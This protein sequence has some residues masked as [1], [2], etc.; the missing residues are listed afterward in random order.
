MEF[1]RAVSYSSQTGDTS[2][3][4]QAGISANIVDRE[5]LYDPNE[6][7]SPEEWQ[8][9]QDTYRG[10]KIYGSSGAALGALTGLGVLHFGQ[11]NRGRMKSPFWLRFLFV[12]SCAGFGSVLMMKFTLNKSMGILQNW[13]SPGR[14]LQERKYVLSWINSDEKQKEKVQT[15][16]KQKT[17]QMNK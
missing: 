1:F 14:L 17:A 2:M 11:F 9:A 4:T 3:M 13:D 5:M 6:P 8:F 7:Y 10:V 12:L 15:Q 16:V